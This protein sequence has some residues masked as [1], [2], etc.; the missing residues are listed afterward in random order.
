MSLLACVRASVHLCMCV[1]ICELFQYVAFLCVLRPYVCVPMRVMCTHMC[2]NTSLHPYVCYT[3]VCVLH[4]YMCATHIC[5]CVAYTHI[6]MFCTYMCVT[7][8]YTH[9]CVLKTCV[10]HPLVC[11]TQLCYT[12]TCVL[13]PYVCYTHICVFHRYVHCPH[14]CITV[15]RGEID[16]IWHFI[17]NFSRCRNAI[18]VKTCSIERLTLHAHHVKIWQSLL[19]GKYFILFLENPSNS[20]RLSGWDWWVSTN[21][22]I[23]I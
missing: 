16:G 19:G 13:H 7:H 5:V 17:S 22:R 4:T 20:P 1:W 15:K 23:S 10:L 8:I 3:H 2:V 12:S 6:Y 21:I 11:F 14:I 18:F 9:I